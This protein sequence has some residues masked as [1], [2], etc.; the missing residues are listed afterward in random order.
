MSNDIQPAL[1]PNLICPFSGEPIQI[2]RVGAGAGYMGIV[3][4]EDGGYSTRIFPHREGLL[5]FL[6]TRGGVKPAFPKRERI[7][8]REILQPVVAGMVVSDEAK[9][10][11]LEDMS[12]E[13]ADK[14][15]EARLSRTRTGAGSV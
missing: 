13:A 3:E 15:L 1:H 12:N 7:Q 11:D 6:S 14:I 8:V 2:V 5:Y 4:S 9:E 10:K